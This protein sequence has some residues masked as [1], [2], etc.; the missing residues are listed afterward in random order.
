M[1]NHGHILVWLWAFSSSSR[2]LNAREKNWKYFLKHRFIFPSQT[3]LIFSKGSILFQTRDSFPITEKMF[4]RLISTHDSVILKKNLPR[5]NITAKGVFYTVESLIG[6]YTVLSIPGL[7]FAKKTLQASY[8]LGAKG[9]FRYQKLS[10][11]AD[12]AFV[13]SVALIQQTFSFHTS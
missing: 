12:F 10:Y 11:I 2:S 5:L 3:Y 6:L 4:F 9:I 8:L 1:E 7:P 13:L